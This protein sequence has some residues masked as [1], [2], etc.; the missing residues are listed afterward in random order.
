[1]SIWYLNDMTTGLYDSCETDL[2]STV[3]PSVVDL[4]GGSADLKS[5]EK[6][7]STKNP[8]QSISQP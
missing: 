7:P 3:R 6:P 1:V 8:T 2:Q 4:D 5:Y